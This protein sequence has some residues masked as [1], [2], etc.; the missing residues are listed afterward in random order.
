MGNMEK[1]FSA[2]LTT[3]KGEGRRKDDKEVKEIDNE[4][5]LDRTLRRVL[6][7]DTFPLI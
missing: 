2:E 4:K 7:L 1:Y 5:D 6:Q 3:K